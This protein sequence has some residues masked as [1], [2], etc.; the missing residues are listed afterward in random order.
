MVLD[1]AAFEIVG[2][3]GVCDSAAVMGGREMVGFWGGGVVRGSKGW[4]YGLGLWASR[5]DG[6]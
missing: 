5:G 3:K 6:D 4:G 1:I 2:G